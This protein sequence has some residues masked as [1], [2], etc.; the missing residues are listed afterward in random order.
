MSNPKFL[1]NRKTG[2]VFPFNAHLLK[3]NRNLEPYNGEDKEPAFEEVNAVI[4]SK[5]VT[6]D[7]KV[8][9]PAPVQQAGAGNQQEPNG[10]P[11]GGTNANAG[12]GTETGGDAGSGQPAVSS[13]DDDQ[14]MVGEV[15]LAEASK[16]Q[17]A[18]FAQTAFG[19]KLDKRKGEDVLRAQVAELLKGQG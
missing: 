7:P 3:R 12:T 19:E 5:P 2:A 10:S 15:P 6:T 1:R 18:D 16:D 9:D 14:P 8:Q 13:E 4:P 17:L 11:D